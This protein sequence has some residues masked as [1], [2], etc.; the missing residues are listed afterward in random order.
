MLPDMTSSMSW[1]VGFLLLFRR[2]MACMIW[3]DWQYPH[4]GNV[5]FD[6]GFLNGMEAVSGDGFDGHDV[7]A[8]GVVH[9]GGAGAH[10]FAV[11]VDGAGTAE[12]H[13][14]AEFRAGES[15]FIAQ[16]PEQR[17][18]GIAVKRTIRAIHF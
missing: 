14:A 8:G 2:A 1:S 11:E 3:P 9:G 10:G 15:K 13:A 5:G 12:S 16:V 4:C 18:L 6:P 17:H 7:L